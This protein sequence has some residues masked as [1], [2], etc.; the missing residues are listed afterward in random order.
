MLST[1]Y[2]LWGTDIV[3]APSE[4]TSQRWRQI[5]DSPLRTIVRE[6]QSAAGVPLGHTVPKHPE[7]GDWGWDN[8]GDAKTRN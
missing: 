7:G 5:I 1:Y 4:L 6:A 3:H 2:V 8:L